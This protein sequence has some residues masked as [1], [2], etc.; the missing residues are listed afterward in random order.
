MQK[1]TVWNRNKVDNKS[2]HICS[3]NSFLWNK[4]YIENLLIPWKRNGTERGNSK[5]KITNKTP[6]P[7]KWF[8]LTTKI[9]DNIKF[10]FKHIKKTYSLG[11]S[12]KSTG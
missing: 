12:G 11:K 8:I 9:I 4:R 5:P 6:I 3:V 1:K 7:T 2:N 10:K